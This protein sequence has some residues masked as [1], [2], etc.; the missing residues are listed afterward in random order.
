MLA[1]VTRPGHT[2]VCV[3]GH[4]PHFTWKVPM[5]PLSLRTLV[6]FLFQ[7]SQ[8]P[9][10]SQL[11]GG[12]G[13]VDTT[14]CPGQGFPASRAL[15]PPASLLGTDGCAEGSRPLPKA[16]SRQDPGSRRSQSWFHEPQPVTHRGSCPQKDSALGLML[17]S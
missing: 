15:E 17:C 8:L 12:K 9:S 1:A 7:V 3:P 4:T 6:L 5:L 10:C 16:H 13:S 14:G 11:G 2:G